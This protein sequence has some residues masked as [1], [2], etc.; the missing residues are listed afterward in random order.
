MY[1]P[2][3]TGTWVP[4]SLPL[5]LLTSGGHHWRPVQTCSVEGLLPLLMLTPSSGV[6]QTPPLGT[7]P[8]A[9]TLW[10]DIPWEAGSTPPHGSRKHNPDGHCSGRYASYWNAFLL[11]PDF[12]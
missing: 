3:R 6:W 4:I 12:N 9:D 5:L 11:K 1:L 7:H 2:L 10:A 8:R